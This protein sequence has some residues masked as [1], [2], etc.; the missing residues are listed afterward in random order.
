MRYHTLVHN[1]DFLRVY[2]QGES[3][4][5][6]QVVVYFCKNKVKHTRIGIISSKKIGK[7][8]TRNRARRVIRHALYEVL[9]EDVGGI[10]LVFVARGR[11]PYLKSWQLAKTIDTILLNNKIKVPIQNK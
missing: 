6:S 4:V 9:P 7:A 8:V 2:R 5:H 10:D 3:V 11:T 1:K